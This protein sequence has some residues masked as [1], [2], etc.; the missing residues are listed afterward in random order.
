[1][2]LGPQA[3]GDGRIGFIGV[4]AQSAE[5]RYTSGMTL[6]KPAAPPPVCGTD[7]PPRSPAK[8]L[9]M[10]PFIR[11]ALVLLA[12]VLMAVNVNSF[13]HSAGL[14]PGGF[15]G[16]TLLI[17][18]IGKRFFNLAIPFT[19]INLV[20]NAVPI[21]ISFRFIGRKFTVYSCVMIVITAFLTDLIPAF[22]VTDDVLLSA[23]FGGLVNAC[24]ISLC[25][26]AGATSGGTDFVAIFISERYGRDAWNYILVFNIVVLTAAGILFGWN[27][28]LYSII[29]QFTATQTLQVLYRRYQKTTLLIITDN[30][31]SLYKI[32]REETHHDA[33][34]FNGTGCYGKTDKT[35]LYSVISG[36]EAR[37]L[38]P[39]IR[40][41]D[42]AAFINVLKSEQIKGRFYNRPKD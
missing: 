39:K 19:P 37:K 15:M 11:F 26:F 42:P 22:P 13:V 7:S 1:M 10:N 31:E 8:P 21:V 33:T 32:I 20:L 9:L 6:K 2:P 5:V 3:A 16:L 29:F 28:A 17:Q 35:M 36:D 12:A 14:F 38:V 24:A 25:L 34:V 4:F 41:C 27:K 18:E 40:R 23:V 30:A